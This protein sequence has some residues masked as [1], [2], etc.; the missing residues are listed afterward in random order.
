MRSRLLPALCG[1]LL[2]LATVAAVPAGITD[3][4]AVTDVHHVETADGETVRVV[5]ERDP[6]FDAAGQPVLLT[7]SPWGGVDDATAGA[8][9]ETDPGDGIPEGIARARADVVGTGGSTGCWDLGG[10]ATA[11]AGVAVVEFLAALPWSNGNVGMTGV[12]YEGAMA[13]MVAATG[14][15]PALKAIM[16]ISAPSSWYHAA[17][18]DGVRYGT[19]TDLPS[20]EGV[21]GPLAGD[22]VAGS[23]PRDDDPVTGLGRAA[24]C[25]PDDQ[26]SASYE[27]GPAFDGYWQERDYTLR[28]GDVRAA[29]LIVHAWDDP[30]AKPDHA[31]RLFEALPVDDRT[32]PQV[33]EGV[34]VKLLRMAPS[35]LIETGEVGADFLRAYLLGDAAARAR[36]EHRTYPVVSIGSAAAGSGLVF[37]SAGTWPLPGTEMHALYLNRTYE[38]DVDGVTV[39]G[40]GTGEVGEL[41]Y[42][43]R[44]DGP[45]AGR[46]GF[47]GPTSG[48][49]DT[50]L[51]TEELSRNDPWSNE[52][53]PGAGPGGQGYY[54]LAFQTTPLTTGVDLAGSAV[55][56]GTFNFL[57]QVSG[58]TLTPILV[59][60]APDG[61]YHTLQRGFL[62][63][64]YRDGLDEAAAPANGWVNADV[65]FLP[66]HHTVPAGHRIG[67]ILQSSNSTW[68]VPGTPAGF[69]SVGLGP[70]EGFT[71]HGTR[72]LLP[73]VDAPERIFED[74]ADA[75]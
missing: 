21:G 2:P 30:D 44:Y 15:A 32:T 68:A 25:L 69:V 36:I 13:T 19:G 61:T 58:Q 7:F 49:L 38:Q 70:L 1:L 27:R 74:F 11:A 40:P 23:T 26:S 43:N 72:L 18:H 39:P 10:P 56:D 45:L 63:V 6:S 9:A 28:A 73:L 34:P 33:S 3:R 12:G 50:G 64:D 47:Y 22:L 24:G 62:N 5:V 60:I 75:A 29:T 14:D 71:D 59:D 53:N 54:S 67:L 20:R 17:Y 8:L 46:G 41:S 66:S 51:A 57:P 55:L 65:T 37:H 42:R 52:G 35:T 31:L 48:W 16:P 4:S